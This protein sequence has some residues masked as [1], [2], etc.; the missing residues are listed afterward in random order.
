M[1]TVK[2]TSLRTLIVAT[3]FTSTLAQAQESELSHN[4]VQPQTEASTQIHSMSELFVQDLRLQ[5][6]H[7]IKHQVNT[8]LSHSAELVKNP[9][10]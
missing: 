9:Q 6:S 2:Q 10:H 8:A 5:L 3:L 7:Q 1:K 4:V